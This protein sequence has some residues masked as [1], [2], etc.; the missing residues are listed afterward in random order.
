MRMLHPAIRVVTAGR[1]REKGLEM[2][3][4]AR[5]IATSQQQER[6]AVV[7]AGEMRRELQRATIRPDRILE[8]AGSRIRDC[9][10]LKNVRI[11]RLI[12][13]GESV[14]GERRVKISQ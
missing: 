9:E 13:Q 6:Q 11:V 3:H 8:P 7:R 1:T 5:P 14:R 10:I 12:A 4:R 2:T